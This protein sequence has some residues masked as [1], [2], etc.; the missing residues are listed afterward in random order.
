MPPHGPSGRRLDIEGLRAIAVLI[1][2][3]YH[4]AWPGFSGGYVGVD[5]FFVISG[6]LITGLLVDEIDRSGGVSLVGFYS[7]R[8]RRLLPASALAIFGTIALSWFVLSPLAMRD[9]LRDAL[10]AFTYTANIQFTSTATDYFQSELPPSALQHMWSLAVEEQFYLVWPIVVLLIAGRA[11]SRRRLGIGLGTLV[12]VSFVAS[13][14]VTQQ[15][16]PW[17]FFML[18]T[19]AWELAIGGLVGMA[20]HRFG[21]VP[22]FGTMPRTVQSVAAVIATAVLVAVVLGFDEQTPFPGWRAALP[23]VAAAVLL[24]TPASTVAGVLRSRPLVWIGAR[25]Y[26]W[27]LWHWPLIVLS[28]EW[29]D[30]PIE[31]PTATLAAIASLGLAALSYTLVERPI[32][33]GWWTSLSPGRALGVGLAGTVLSIGLALVL[34]VGSP[35]V[36]TDGPVAAPVE[37]G[38]V[39]VASDVGRAPVDPLDVALRN[40]DVPSNLRPSLGDSRSDLPV[41]YGDGCHLDIAETTLAPCEY[42]DV[43]AARTMVLFGD[44]NAAMWFPAIESIA[45]RNGWKLVS[46]TKS[47]CP[48][49][50]LTVQLETL[51]RDYVEC[52]Q[53]RDAVID[54]VERMD[55]ELVLV[56][57]GVRSP[58]AFERSGTD[59]ASAMSV[60]VGAL[61][62]ANRVALLGAAPVPGF[63]VPDCLSANGESASE[64]SFDESSPVVAARRELE[65]EV[66]NRSGSLLV[67]VV[68]WFCASGACPPIVGDVLVYRDRS[69]FTTAY[70]DLLVVPLTERLTGLGVD[71]R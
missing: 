24:A 63:D 14:V 60:T 51:N 12:V 1:V 16:Q 36:G 49:E 19:R 70:A 45:Q 55:P 4:A 42:G 44:S 38:R 68:D 10:A 35:S 58:S 41:V 5:V 21:T 59:F 69:H 22:R 23:V 57:S 54:A 33:T 40:D 2:V 46:W 13:V 52:D 71:L 62:A 65:A 43:D 61:D 30:G 25:S 7:R 26:G 64:C 47:A 6:F 28:A 3:F 17:A 27:Y 11:A 20:V 29:N 34:V 37:L 9:L 32:R 56:G 39:P 15:N 67:P 50:T 8:I 31:A 66:E 53:W 48:P 18:P